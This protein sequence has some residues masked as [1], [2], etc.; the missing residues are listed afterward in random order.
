MESLKVDEQL[1][2]P[3][4]YFLQDESQTGKV[5]RIYHLYS[6][7]S[8]P[9]PSQLSF[10]PGVGST[11]TLSPLTVSA[12]PQSTPKLNFVTY[13]T[14]LYRCP[15][16]TTCPSCETWVT[17]HVTYKVGRMAWL[18]CLV[19]VLCGLVLGCCL[20][21][22]FVNYFKDAYHTCPHCRLVLHVQRRTCCA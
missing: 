6:P 19:F 21:P 18:M 10:S 13:E 20:I 2:S 16:R 22:F 5:G 1:P 3:P 7:L 8:P 9:P 12:L 15:A 11:Q 14:E 17:T 4:P